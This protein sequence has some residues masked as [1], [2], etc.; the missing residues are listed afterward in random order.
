M[1]VQPDGK[2]VLIGK[3][4]P[5]AGALAR[6]NPDGSLDP[7]FGEGG[8]V[9][10]HRLPGFRALALQPDGR[11]VGAAVGGS[12]L[13]RYLPDGTPDPSFAGGGVGGTD[14]PE[15][16]HS[17]FANYGPS[18]IVIRP[19]GSIVVAAIRQLGEGE[20]ESW[21][22]RY[23]SDGGLLEAVGHIS[24][25]GPFSFA[26]ISDLLEEPDGSLIGAGSIDNYGGNRLTEPLLARFVPGSGADFDPSFGGGAGLVRPSFPRKG[27]LDNAFAVIAADE[28]KLLAA[29][30]ASG[31]FV[32]ARFDQDG[33]LDPSFGEGGFVAPPIQRPAGEPPP[34]YGES[35]S[36][37]V[38]DVAVMPSGGILAAGGTSQ[39]GTWE[40]AGKVPLCKGCQQPMLA[41]FAA[42]GHLDP[43][44]GSGGLLRLAKPDGT[45]FD[46]KV[47]QVAP[48][49]DGKALVA[50]AV[51]SFAP[52]VARLN[53]DGSYDPSFGRDGLVTL[54]FPC[55]DQ[56]EA[57][58]RQA[59]CTASAKVELRLRRPR[60]RHP[61]LFL[62][63]RPNLDWAGID[64]LSLTLPAGLRVTRGFKA[65]LRVRGVDKRIKVHVSV[66]RRR[67]RG[68]ILYLHGL[69]NVG[70]VRVQLR[71]GALGAHGRNF[72]LRRRLAF[73]VEAEFEYAR[74]GGWAGRDTVVRRVG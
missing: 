7:S 33:N 39:W 58:R 65:K 46:G 6:L 68:E 40:Q 49:P 71:R 48:L 19:D 63:V 17:L 50:G 21:V 16:E 60:S 37:R 69:G 9:I 54:R 2:I 13:A 28:G 23:G 18:A 45:T 12:N 41:R 70:E 15:Q 5:E 47:E 27:N 30:T 3:A 14:E 62:R 61:A 74:W 43:S 29:G 64:V 42:D 66:P 1:A 57:Q 52:F 25:P 31:T 72:R 51:T 38:E 8:F 36:S 32:V 11:I 56:S 55:S 67:R 53:P 73:E 26:A 59:G 24:R 10:D 22:R 4:W 20:A 44:F 35:A 34:A